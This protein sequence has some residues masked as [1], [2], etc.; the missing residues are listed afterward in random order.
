MSAFSPGEG[1]L[2]MNY[3]DTGDFKGLVRM[4]IDSSRKGDIE[5]N[6]YP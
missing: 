2:T 5:R 3:Q 1:I 4:E 6:R